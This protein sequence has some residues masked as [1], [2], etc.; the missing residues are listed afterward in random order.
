MTPPTAGE[1][2]RGSERRSRKALKRSNF[3]VLDS[4]SGANLE[5]GRAKRRG[6]EKK[7]P[8]NCNSEDPRVVGL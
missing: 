8:K 6:K 4:S 3:P 1:P 5:F 2:G 7:F